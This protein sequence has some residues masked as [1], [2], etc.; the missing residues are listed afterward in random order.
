MEVVISSE[1]RYDDYGN[2][3]FKDK[4]GKEHKIGTKRENFDELVNLVAENPDRAVKFTFDEYKGR[5]YIVGIEL[6]E[7]QVD[8]E[9]ITEQQKVKQAPQAKPAP[10]I[11]ENMEWKDKQIDLKFWYGQLG[12]RIGDESIDRD[13]PNMAVKIKGQYY[14]QMETVTGISMKK[15]D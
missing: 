10:S 2:F 4:G 9:K 1:N 15:E 7:I 12:N 6:L 13:F 11:R 5:S 3:F 8:K 14:K